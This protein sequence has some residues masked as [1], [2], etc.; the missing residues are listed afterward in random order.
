[1]VVKSVFFDVGST[2]MH[3]CPSVAEMFAAVARER[4]HELSVRDVEPFMPEVDAYYE[5]EYLRDGDFWC[6]HERAV[7]IWLDMY[8]M[9]AD[10]TG[11]SAERDALSLEV[12]GRYRKGDAWALYDDVVP[13]LRT[14]KR[15]GYRLG[16]ISNWDAELEQLLREVGLLPYFDVVIS[17]AAE[18]YRKP[19]PI[20]F[21]LALEKMGAKASETVHVGD[22]PEADGAASAV[23]I[24]PVIIDRRDSHADCAMHRVS[25]LCDLPAVIE[26]LRASSSP[27]LPQDF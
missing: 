22:L 18:G 4:G 24:T 20:V 15:C 7:A 1:M 13:C 5:R 16:V 23:G 10:R 2:L 26:G 25:T 17:S 12:H 3:A 8:R 19:N 9:L 14:L 6:S 11:L 21:E 27:A